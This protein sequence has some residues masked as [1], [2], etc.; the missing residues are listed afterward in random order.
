MGLRPALGQCSLC[1]GELCSDTE[2][3]HLFP[4]I[5]ERA[6]EAVTLNILG[7]CCATYILGPHTAVGENKAT[8][9]ET[10]KSS[11]KGLDPGS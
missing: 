7:K 5:R 4:L 6:L 9:T 3:G 1:L 10:Q 8:H 2:R 11:L